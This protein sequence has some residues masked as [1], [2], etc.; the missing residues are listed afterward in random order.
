MAAPLTWR[1]LAMTSDDRG[2]T[3]G[4]VIDGFAAHCGHYHDTR[5]EAEA[6]PWEP[7]LPPGAV[8]AGFVRQVRDDRADGRMRREQGVL[9]TERGK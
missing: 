8:Y 6:C 2:L 1:I 9:F 5:E 7:E 3:V 4:L